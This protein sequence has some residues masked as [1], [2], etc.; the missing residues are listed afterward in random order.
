MRNLFLLFISISILSFIP[1]AKAQVSTYTFLQ[2]S[3]VYTG[4]TG[5]LLDSATS[6]TGATSLDDVQYTNLPIGFS[7]TMNGNSYTTFSMNTNGQIT[8]GAT[9]PGTTNYTPISSTTAYAGCVAMLARDLQ[10]I[11]GFTATRTLSSTT[12]TG[13]TDFTG[14]VVG[15]IVAGTGIAAGTRV[16]S[17]NTGSGTVELSA[18]ATAAGTTTLNCCS[19]ELRY[20][21]TG[22]AGS[23]VM[24][25]QYSNFKRFSSA[26]LT[27]NFNFQV[28]LYETTNVIEIVYGPSIANSTAIVPQVGLRGASNSDFNNRTTTTD[29]SASTAGGA[30]NATMTLSNTVFPAS[31][32]KYQWTPAVILNDV[33]VSANLAPTGQ[34]LVGSSPV[35]PSAK[36]KNYGISNQNVPFMVVYKITG[37]VSYQDSMTTTV[38]ANSEVTV[39]FPGNFNPN[40]LGNYSVTIYTEL[41]SDQNRTNDTLKSA[42]A[43]S[44][45]ANYGNDSGYFYVNNLG[46]NQPSYP[47]YCW[48]DTAGSI[49]VLVN[50]VTSPGNTL[51]GSVDD[52]YYI[53][54]LKNILL[55]LGQDTTDKHLK[56]NGNCYDSIFPGSNG[57]IGLTQQFGVTS[58]TAWQVDGA[59]VA[60]NALLPIWHDF[61]L[62][63]LTFQSTNRLS[64]KVEGSQLIITYD[65]VAAFAPENNWASYQVVIDIVTGCGGPNSNFRYTMADTTG[66]RTSAAFLNDYIAQYPVGDGQ[67]TTFRNYVS[68]YSFTGAPNV[69]GGYVSSV[70]PLPATPSTQVNIKR[71]LFNLTT[72]QGLAV[73]FGPNQN[74]LSKF[75]CSLTLSVALSLQGPQSNPTPRVRDT[76]TVNLR[77]GNSPYSV[78][79]SYKVFLDSAYNNV[80]GYS[81]GY[82]NISS[83]ELQKNT[84]YYIE[85][86]NRNTVTSWSTSTSTATDILSY[87]FTTN[88]NKT[89]GSNATLVNGAAS[90]YSGDLASP[91]IDVQDGCVDLS[92]IIAVNNDASQFTTGPYVLADLNFDGFVDLTDLV[93]VYNNAANFICSVFPPGAA[94]FTASPA[95]NF[96]YNYVRDTKVTILPDPYFM[97]KEAQLNEDKT[98]VKK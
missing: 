28:K 1:D 46:T 69:Y 95:V 83:P 92:D 98:E 72:G 21:T 20:E 14:I 86:L 87:D 55:A 53:L 17:Y 40:T 32:Q 68:G 12:L 96:N 13:V 85:I 67:V 90:F 58:L 61:D 79:A 57:I 25:L 93:I 84:P 41:G 18:A 35:Q 3:S 54:S 82:K 70:N 45:P 77:N 52:G 62:G 27:D 33:G 88:N 22:S 56:Y 4:I 24:T 42:F 47:T 39:N 89:Y 71:P 6:T 78:V 23:R 7:F 16:V 76:V 37:P 11:F 51:V 43:V 44:P 65:K 31:G 81:Y 73:E 15:K 60:N 59:K 10:G 38:N 63:T 8:F 66:G 80:G 97:D 26:T 2:T 94:E 34:I 74:N 36:V 30:N 49:S 75:N 29:W 48:K 9:G 50:G 64:Y 19:G 5:T 91:I